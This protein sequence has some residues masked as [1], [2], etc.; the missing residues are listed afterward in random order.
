MKNY[1][2]SLKQ[3]Q[4][5]PILGRSDM[6]KNSAGGYGF[7]IS[8]KQQ[9]ERFLLCGTESGTY[10]ASSSKLTEDNAKSIV[11]LIKSNGNLVV[12][13]LVNLKDR[14]PKKDTIVFVLAL[15]CTYGNQEVKNLAYKE[16]SKICNTST[17][18]FMFVSQVNALRGWSRGLR[19]AVARWYEDKNYKSLAYQVT[20]YRNR[21][22][23]TH[24]DVIRLAHPKIPNPD[25]NDVVAYA[26]GKSAGNS[27]LLIQGFELAQSTKEIDTLVHVIRNSQLTWEM[28]PTDK[29]NEP[30][31]LKAL[32]PDMPIQALIRNL[33]RF[34]KAGLITGNTK[35]TQEIISKL[36]EGLP[37]SGIHPINLVNQMLTYSKGRGD[38]G[39]STWNVNQKI[40]DALHEGYY[41][42]LEAYDPTGKNILIGLDVSGSMNFP[43]GGTQLRA[44]NLGALLSATLLRIEP[45]TEV[46]AFDTKLKSVN[47][48]ARTDLTAILNANFNGGG[49][50]CSLPM[51]HALKTKN[52]YDA[53]IILT[54]SET[55]AG[56]KHALTLI[57]SYRKIS[58]NVKIIEVAMVANPNSVLPEDP[59]F[60]RV[61]GFDSSVMEVINQFIS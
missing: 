32:L 16:I 1:A 21:A 18:L 25:L 27:S 43:V 20:K 61:V 24:K 56:E 48:G 39:S 30:E 28:I 40:V 51:V 19:R 12:S 31:V 37:N 29:L 58:P 7:K 3:T 44:S 11:S 10:Y 35:T 45:N 33:N 14:V 42:L 55:W 34:D 4:Q 8:Q 50:D 6:I 59:N 2:A 46:V 22:G 57:E 17:H 52:V 38:K 26:V 5:T 23:F 9:L 36:K 49:T 41:T 47:F 60:L 13:T 54:D 53:I 15:V